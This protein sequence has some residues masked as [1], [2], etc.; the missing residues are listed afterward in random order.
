[1]LG[2][3]VSRGQILDRGFVDRHVAAGHDAGADGF[4]NRFQPV[5]GQFHPAG[6]R[7]PGQLHPVAAGEDLFLPMEREVVAV[8]ADEEV[9][10]QTGRGQPA[11]PQARGQRRDDGGE[12]GV[13]AMRVF[14]AD[15]APAQEAAGLVIKLLIHFLADAAPGGGLRWHWLGLEDDFD[16]RKIFRQPWRGIF[17]GTGRAWLGPRRQ[18]LGRWCGGQGAVRQEQFELGGVEG[19]AARAEDAA[20]ERIDLLAQEQ[21][22]PAATQPARLPA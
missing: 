18:R 7:L 2:L 16:E 12:V 14:A 8:F 3:A 15:G 22:S 19:F 6:Q 13:G 11:F 10:E 21:R 4:V 1:M 17:A 20:H 9:R 5:D